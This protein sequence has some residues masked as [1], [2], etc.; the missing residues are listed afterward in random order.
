MNKPTLK[1]YQRKAINEKLVLLELQ[2]DQLYKL[3]CPLDLAVRQ[4]ETQQA[5]IR[6]KI[7]IQRQLLNKLKP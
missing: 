3:W 7:E 2:R 6:K 5:S 1:C 4:I